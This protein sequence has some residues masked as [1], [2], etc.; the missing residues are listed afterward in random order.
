LFST[1]SPSGFK[2]FLKEVP[3]LFTDDQNRILTFWASEEEVKSALFLM[4]PEKAL[5]PDGMTALFFQ[6]SWSIIKKD[7]TDMVKFF[8]Q[9]RIIG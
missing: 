7:I 6:K 9:N 1:T 3:T 5:G 4:H 2:E 8:F